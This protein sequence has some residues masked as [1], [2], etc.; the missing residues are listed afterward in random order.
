MADIGRRLHVDH[1]GL[2][3]VRAEDGEAVAVVG[4]DLG[5][6][7]GPPRAQRAHEFGDQPLPL[8]SSDTADDR[9][10]R[11]EVQRERVPVGLDDKPLES[12]FLQSA[13]RPPHLSR[14]THLGGV[15]PQDGSTRG[16]RVSPGTTRRGPG[17][18]VRPGSRGIMA[19]VFRNRAGAGCMLP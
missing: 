16:D 13:F 5:V 6:D 19:A 14:K 9:E 10:A 8:E 7:T 2:R 4:R 11:M 17:G 18:L 15:S 3:P 12:H 1:A